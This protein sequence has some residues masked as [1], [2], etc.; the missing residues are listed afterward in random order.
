M[1]ILMSIARLYA[2]AVYRKEDELDSLATQK[3]LSLPDPPRKFAARCRPDVIGEVKVVWIDEH[4]AKNGVLVYLHGGAYYFGPVKEH[5]DYIATISARTQMA[6]LM[7]DYRMAPLYPFP[8]GIEDVLRV[9]ENMPRANWFLLG[10]SSGAAMAIATALKLAEAGKD[11]PRKILL[12]CPWPDA[13]LE[14]PDIKVDERK[15]PLMTAKRLATAAREYAAGEDLKHPLI[16]PLFAD[17]ADLT[18]LPPTLIQSGTADLLI[19][20]CR[21]FQQKCVAAGMD[22]KYEEY[23]DALH[24]FMMLNA[25]PETRKA[26]AS[27]ADFLSQNK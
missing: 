26:I 16:S 20:D 14:N 2:R 23:A 8:Q 18:G 13:S 12:M 27:Q 9:I 22:V 7:V 15:D 11:L 21:K 24:D 3:K 17:P 25:L 19:S 10:D 5:W 1:S 6:G 4:N